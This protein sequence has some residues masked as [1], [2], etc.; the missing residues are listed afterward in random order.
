M[1]ERFVIHRYKSTSHAA[2]VGAF[3]GS[4]VDLPGDRVVGQRV[5]GEVEQ[6]PTAV[7]EPRD[8]DGPAVR[9]REV[10]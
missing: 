6:F 10:V 3:L 9:E 8:A 4:E 1:D 7:Y 5:V 2:V